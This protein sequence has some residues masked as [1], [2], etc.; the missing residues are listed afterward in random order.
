MNRKWIV[1]YI[2]A[3]GEDLVSD[4]TEVSASS[5]GV[6]RRKVESDNRLVSSV[7]R[8]KPIRQKKHH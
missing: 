4:K 3:R 5:K 8:S 7:E 2:E 1:C 6:A